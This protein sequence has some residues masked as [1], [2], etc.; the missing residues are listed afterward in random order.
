MAVQIKRPE[1]QH[2]QLSFHHLHLDF[3]PE[4]LTLLKHTPLGLY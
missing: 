3:G 2:L 4:V 1:N